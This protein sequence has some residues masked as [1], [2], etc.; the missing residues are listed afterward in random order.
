LPAP[1]LSNDRQNLYRPFDLI[2]RAFIPSRIRETFPV[3]SGPDWTDNNYL[4]QNESP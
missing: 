1:F 4:L 2:T 3:L